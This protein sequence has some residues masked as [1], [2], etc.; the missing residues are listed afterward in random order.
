M[1][2]RT[3]D[4]FS[5]EVPEGWVNASVVNLV[6]LDSEVFQPTLVV[7]RED[8]PAVDVERYARSLLPSIARQMR[9]H[10][11]LSSGAATVA[12]RPA[13]RLEHRFETPNGVRARQIQH[14]LVHETDLLVVALT[15]AEAEYETR[16]PH[17]D[18]IL[19]SLRLSNA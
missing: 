10:Q 6:G 11:L 13:F 19:A 17:F 9:R 14:F 8:S 3:F 1:A 2:R 16:R 15:C 4:D 5:V 18:A 12:G 7:T